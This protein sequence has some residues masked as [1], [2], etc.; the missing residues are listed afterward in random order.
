MSLAIISMLII[1]YNTYTY[2]YEIETYMN[3]MQNS[4][5]SMPIKENFV[6]YL[7]DWNYKE[8]RYDEKIADIYNTSL[9]NYKSGVDFHNTSKK[10]YQQYIELSDVKSNNPFFAY[11]CIKHILRNDLLISLQKMFYVSY[12]EFYS[13]SMHDITQKISDDIDKTI[14]KMNG[15]ELKDPVY[16]LIF[17]APYFQFNNESY[18]ARHDSVNNLK[19]SYEQNAENINIGEK[20][21]L[22][23][24]YVMYPYYYHDPIDTNK[25]LPY[26]HEEGYRAFKL[27]F[28]DSRMTR[29]KLCF[30]ECNGVNSYACGCLNS[31]KDLNNAYTSKC[32]NLNN[33]YFDYGMIYAVNKF[34]PLFQNKFITKH[35]II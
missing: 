16:F 25:I 28:N 10:Y 7:I 32:I 9:E 15:Q 30:I 1:L 18:I 19:P 14:A 26:A 21:L 22:T 35:Y 3:Y 13:I 23:K 6:N 2:K 17:Q 31:E 27:F 34:N 29:D 4:D 33:E 12:Y 20:P 11:G 24:I 8:K 5:R